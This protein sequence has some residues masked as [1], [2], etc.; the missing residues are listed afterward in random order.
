MINYSRNDHDEEDNH[1]HIK[2]EQFDQVRA[3]KEA[4]SRKIEAKL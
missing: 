2:T 4:I 3:T 1:H